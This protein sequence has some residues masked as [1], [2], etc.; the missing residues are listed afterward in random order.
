MFLECK[1]GLSVL[2]VHVLGLK[3]CVRACLCVCVRACCRMDGH[4][5]SSTICKV[6]LPPPPSSA[7][8]SLPFSLLTIPKLPPSSTTES[9]AG[10]AHKNDVCMCARSCLPVYY[11]HKHTLTHTPPAHSLSFSI[12]LSLSLSLYTFCLLF[13]IPFPTLI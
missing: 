8:P 6:L 13:S 5:P 9:V 1:G 11:M 3:L 10:G 2:F 7:F 12:S 4:C